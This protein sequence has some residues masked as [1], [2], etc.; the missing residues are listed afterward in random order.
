MLVP[1][2]EVG[3][4]GV[5]VPQRRVPVRVAVRLAWRVGRQVLVLVMFVVDVEVVVLQRLVLVL[6]FM[7]LGQVEPHADAH[8]DGGHDE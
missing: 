5:R 8:E 4:V 7:P 2:M 1:V 6:V 3:I